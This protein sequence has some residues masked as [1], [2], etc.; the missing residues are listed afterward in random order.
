MRLCSALNRSD[1][2]S[3]EMPLSQEPDEPSVKQ[4]NEMY[5][6]GNYRLK[7]YLGVFV[8]VLNL[9]SICELRQRACEPHC[10]TRAMSKR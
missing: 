8:V 4:N 3:Y 9:N 1:R 2:H 5:E 6:Y 10:E 7:C